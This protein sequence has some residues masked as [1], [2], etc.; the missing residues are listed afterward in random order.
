MYGEMYD[1]ESY[2][3]RDERH[4]RPYQ[5]SGLA[6]GGIVACKQENCPHGHCP[7]CGNCDD[8]LDNDGDQRTMITLCFVGDV[9]NR[10]VGRILWAECKHENWE[11]G[12]TIEPHYIYENGELVDEVNLY[13]VECNECGAIGDEFVEGEGSTRIKWDA[14]SFEAESG[15]C[16]P[17]GQNLDGQFWG[18]GK[19]RKPNATSVEV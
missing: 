6:F 5:R 9:V 2:V 10:L 17:C 7:R 16:E 14:E 12:E 1:A 8:V 4:L 15:Y 19:A 3:R 11:R 13:W 18:D